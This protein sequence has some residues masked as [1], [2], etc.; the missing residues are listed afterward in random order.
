MFK[1]ARNEAE[2]QIYLQLNEK[3]NDFFELGAAILSYFGPIGSTPPVFL[4]PNTTGCWLNAR[5]RATIYRRWLCFCAPRS[6]PSQI[7]P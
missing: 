6:W 5:T 3:I 4:Q 7:C 2:E 1:D